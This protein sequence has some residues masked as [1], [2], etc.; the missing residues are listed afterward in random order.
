MRTFEK[1]QSIIV[2]GESGAGKTE[3]AKIVVKYL[4][5]VSTQQCDASE[6]ASAQAVTDRVNSTSPIL[7]AFGNAKTERND[8]SSRFGKFMKIQFAGSGVMIGS[9][10]EV[11]LLEKSRIVT[12]GRHER[13]Y[14]SFYQLLRGSSATQRDRLHLEDA[15]Q[16]KSLAVGNATVITGV[17]DAE[18]YQVVCEAMSIVGMSEDDKQGVWDAVAGVL[19]CLRVEFDENADNESGVTAA[20]EQFLDR[21]AQIWAIST[22]ELKK[23]LVSTTTTVRGETFVRRLTASQATDTKDGLSKALYERLFLCLVD[24]INAL[25]NNEPNTVRWIGLL[26]IFGFESFDAKNSFEQ[27]CINLANETLQNHYNTVIFTQDM[28]ECRAEGIDTASVVFYDNQPCL[29]LIC[30]KVSILAL[31]DEECVLGKG[32]D[33]GFCDKVIT[34]FK[35]HANLIPPKTEKGVFTIRHYA[36]DVKYTVSGFREKNMDPLKDELKLLLR[37]S[38]SALVAALLPEPEDRRGKALTVGGIFRQQLH[39]LMTTINSTHPHWIRCV[40]PHPAKKAKMFHGAE[41]MKQLCCAGVLETVRIRKMSY[42]MRFTFD[43][44]WRMFRNILARKLD[45]GTTRDAARRIIDAVGLGPEVAQVGKTKAFLKFDGYHQTTEKLNEVNAKF[46]VT[47]LRFA[48]AKWS[49]RRRHALYL[50]SRVSLITSF[51]VGRASDAAVKRKELAAREQYLLKTF[52]TLLMLQ[53]Q[54]DAQRKKVEADLEDSLRV[55][56]SLRRIDFDKVRAEW[57]AHVTLMHAKQVNATI[58]TESAVRR[59]LAESEWS[60]F[61]ILTR[62]FGF[63]REEGPARRLIM[64]EAETASAALQEAAYESM[65]DA[66]GR[67]AERARQV[68]LRKAAQLEEEELTAR[69]AVV[70]ASMREWRYVAGQVAVMLDALVVGVPRIWQQE[71]DHRAAITRAERDGMQRNEKKWW[72]D[73]AAKDRHDSQVIHAFEIRNRTLLVRAEEQEIIAILTEYDRQFEE[74]AARE[75]RRIKEEE[76]AQ[77][78]R[79]RLQAARWQREEEQRRAEQQRLAQM[80]WRKAQSEYKRQAQSDAMEQAA[81][82]EHVK[83]MAAGAAFLDGVRRAD[84]YHSPSTATRIRAPFSSHAKPLLGFGVDQPP[85]TSPRRYFH[86]NNAGQPVASS[87]PN[88]GGAQTPRAAV[89]VSSPI[90]PSPTPRSPSSGPSVGGGRTAPPVPG[91]RGVSSSADTLARLKSLTR[92]SQAGGS[93]LRQSIDPYSNAWRPPNAT[94]A[95][96]PDGSVVPLPVTRGPV[97]PFL[98]L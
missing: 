29:D 9:L 67:V 74:A 64:I 38:K 18:D 71:A 10:I 91:L 75:W 56:S 84:A 11:Y 53:T 98:E 48:K 63:E 83:H 78:A 15:T 51:L 36:G 94:S 52:R 31:L 62:L 47:L 27:V 79:E 69:E 86:F 54:E 19:N 23:E 89:S 65:R 28:E 88:G 21:A 12:H 30:G 80:V 68:F 77:R 44:F 90:V 60:A 16:Y 72:T 45:G 3:S 87:S 39:R 37:S 85:L 8:N 24:K 50:N 2:S 20:T 73:K 46:A 17:D 95:Y 96:L 93:T 59:D 55:V 58:D 4:G 13:S 81:R 61:D 43:D 14:H 49:M 76:L 26:D 40:K 7:E 97:D 92:R 41:V 33:D 42:S 66:A 32:S 35:S 6:R 34:T 70:H 22:E 25:I 57:I 5:K 82:M 1:N